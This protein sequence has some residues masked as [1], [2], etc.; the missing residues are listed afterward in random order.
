MAQGTVDAVY[1]GGDIS[2]AVGYLGKIQIYLILHYQRQHY[3]FISLFVLSPSLSQFTYFHNLI[4]TTHYLS[5]PHSPPSHTSQHTITAVW[6]F[7]LEMISPFTSGALFLT[8]LG[9]HESDSPMS[10]SYYD[11]TDSGN[12]NNFI[13]NNL[14]LTKSF[15][16]T[17]F[18]NAIT[19]FGNR[20]TRY[21][22]HF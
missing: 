8:N 14:I 18:Q 1:I 19:V 15:T 12:I 16:L 6:D 5:H 10:A 11:Y 13:Q 20:K 3:F 21:F 9:N 17:T 2:Y 7:F 22:F 4:S